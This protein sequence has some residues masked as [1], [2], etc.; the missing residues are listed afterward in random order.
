MLHAPNEMMDVLLRDV[1]AGTIRVVSEV[2][3]WISAWRTGG[4]VNSVN[5]SII[6][7]P[8]THSSHRRL[9]RRLSIVIKQQQHRAATCLFVPP[10]GPSPEVFPPQH[11]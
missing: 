8:L 1:V 3:D 11:W 4:K 6:Q 10:P 7:E 2:L 9:S 5:V